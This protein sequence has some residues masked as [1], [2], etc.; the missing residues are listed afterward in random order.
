MKCEEEILIKLFEPTFTDSLC[1]HLKTVYCFIDINAFVSNGL[2]PMR[3]TK[4]KIF[5]VI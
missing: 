2:Q 5:L 3:T 4:S 1:E